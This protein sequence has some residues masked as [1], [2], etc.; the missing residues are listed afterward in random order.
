MG[1][2]SLSK[3]EERTVKIQYASN[4]HLDFDGRLCFEL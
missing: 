2:V 1:N 3:K 4:L